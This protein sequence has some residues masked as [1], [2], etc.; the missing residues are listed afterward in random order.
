MKQ[1]RCRKCG[2]PLG[3]KRLANG[4]WCPTNPD[5][6]DHWDLCRQTFLASLS[7]SARAALRER[8][9]IE[10]LPKRTAGKKGDTFG[11]HYAGELPPWD[12][13]LAPFRAF[14]REEK[15]AKADC[16][17]TG[18]GSQIEMTHTCGTPTVGVS[19]T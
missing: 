2:L 12:D 16:A 4:S 6:S 3:W 15:A 17:P 10:G 8:D 13:S 9:R 5:G 1:S 7:P 11:Y 14:T 19:S 18:V